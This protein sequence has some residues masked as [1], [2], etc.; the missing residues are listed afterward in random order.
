[1]NAVNADRAV[2]HHSARKARTGASFAAI[3]VVLLAIARPAIA[4]PI[5]VEDD[6]GRTITLEAPAKRIVTLAPFLTELAFSAGAGDRVV[7]VSAHSDYPPQAVRRPQ[8]AN[9]AGVSIEQVASLRPDLALAWKDSLRDQDIERLQRLGVAVFVAQ[10]RG[11]HDPPRLLRAIGRLAGT[12]AEAAAEGYRRTLERLRETHAGRRRLRAFVEI[13]HRPLTTIAGAHW[14]NEALLVCGAQ[15]VF[16]ELPG[17]A[18]LVSWEQL[19]L[20]DPEV[21][22]GAGSAADAAAFEAQWR[23]HPALAAVRDSRLV[24]AHADTIQRPTLRL[25]EGVA[26]LCESLQRVR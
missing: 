13:W 6:L 21:V 20:K 24:F 14:I 12:D 9:A 1:M 17:V 23:T 18:P 22:V 25:A 10:A 11:L 19:Y 8:V 26:R 2:P 15:N 7:G 5:T 3:C 16:A 4:A